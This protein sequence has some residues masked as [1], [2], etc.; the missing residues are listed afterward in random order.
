M[1]HLVS[2]PMS[3]CNGISLGVDSSGELLNTICVWGHNSCYWR[4][5][6]HYPHELK[7]ILDLWTRR[8]ISMPV[9]LVYTTIVCAPL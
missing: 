8:H 5:L 1:K 3:S 9:S 2:H 7:G 6:H 4:I